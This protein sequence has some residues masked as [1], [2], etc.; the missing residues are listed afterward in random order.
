MI[1]PA[2]V[3]DAFRFFM[4]RDQIT[5]DDIRWHVEHHDSLPG[6]YRFL[7]QSEEFNVR[8]TASREAV[9]EAVRSVA[10]S[11]PRP[12]VAPGTLSAR[13]IVRRFPVYHGPGTPGFVTDHLGG[14]THTSFVHWFPTISGVVWESPLVVERF[15][16]LDEWVGTLRAVSEADP[17]QPFVMMEFGAGWAPWCVSTVL[18]CRMRGIKDVHVVGVEG[19]AG[20]V[21]FARQ[22]FAHNNVSPSEYTLV[23]GI[24]GADG[25][26]EFPDLDDP[27]ADY[28]AAIVGG[29]DERKVRTVKVPSY[30]IATLLKSYPSVN[31][32]HIDIQGSEADAI[33][34]SLKDVTRKVRR[35]VIGTH[36][37][38]IEHELL[39]M[40]SA[41]GWLLEADTGCV[42]T[43][44]DG[45][46][47][48]YKDGEQ[49][50]RNPQAV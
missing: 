21:A 15:H 20:H 30:S 36:S 10:P 45:K 28:G 32:L 18:A 11:D 17:N 13:E 31:L 2:Q 6:F 47:V 5:E 50:W 8:M 43:Y 19:S 35:M 25:V 4:G 39:A 37:R 24:V 34:A 7:M 23:E 12:T 26:A 42:F 1:T 33:R 27:A 46:P 3:R 22:H 44:P 48:L 9:R 16:S 29:G 49:V 14:K 40:L 41:D 38:G